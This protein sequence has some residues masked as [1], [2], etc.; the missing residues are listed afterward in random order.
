M[1]GPDNPA[2][3]V[4]AWQ[5]GDVS[6]PNELQ[7]IAAIAIGGVVG[8]SARWAVATQLTPGAVDG[9]PWQTFVVNVIGCLLIGIAAGRIDRPSIAWAFV[10][11]GVLGGFTT[12]SGFAVQLNDFAEAGET[13]TMVT[14]LAATLVVGFGA[15]AAGERLSGSVDDDPE[16]IE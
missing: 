16:G 3:T 15:L 7:T 12:M 6:E 2:E 1:S 9:F 4:A 11:T 14:Y 13:T 5:S 10:A 8:S